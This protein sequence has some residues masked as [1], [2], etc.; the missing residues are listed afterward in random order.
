[1]DVNVEIPSISQDVNIPQVISITGQDF[2]E[3]IE[4]NIQIFYSTIKDIL[5]NPIGKDE[6]DKAKEQTSDDLLDKLEN[7]DSFAWY[8]YDNLSSNSKI[9]VRYSFD[10]LENISTEDIQNVAKKYFNLNKASLVVVHPNKTEPDKTNKV[11]FKGRAELT[12]NKDIQE[13]DLPNNVH[14]IFD[15]RP[16]II[17]TTVSCQILFENKKKNN[18]G[19]IDAMQSSLVK[20]KNE[21]F[22]AANWIDQNGIHIR[23]FGS[24]ENIQNIINNIKNELI[25]PE[26]KNNELEKT[27]KNQKEKLQKEKRVGPRDLLEYA[28]CPK[29]ENEIYPEWLQTND[30]KKYYNYLLSQSQG[31]I[32]I[33]TPRENIKQVESEVIKSLSEIPM[34]KPHDFSKISSQYTPIDLDKTRIFLEK[35]DASDNVQIEKNYKIISNGNIKDEAGIMLISLILNNKLEKTLREDLGLTYG[36]TSYTAKPSPKHSVLTISTKIA[37]TPL[38]AST[39]TTLVQIDNI[40]ND[41]INSKVDENIL[42]SAKKQIKSNILIPAETSVDRN[43][44]FESNYR[45]S[46]DI[47]YSRKLAASIDT[48]TPD[49]LQKI[50]QK[51]L[52]KPHVWGISGNKNAIEA[53]NDYISTLGEIKL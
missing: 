26:F 46:Y 6:L 28:D 18:N 33:T 8:L 41:T 22:L 35:N 50:A 31:T 14:L 30:L 43:M 27:K 47:D 49:N 39:K 52:T 10:H 34:V 2:D 44:D 29:N 42:N 11:L 20:D 40:I 17:K 37:K 3:K 48:I 7:N 38:E 32:I 24:P 16:G 5:N 51:Y 1:M 13:Y 53:N 23:K 25:N 9:D 45:K 4:R 21:K 36:A 12:N 19:I 15:T